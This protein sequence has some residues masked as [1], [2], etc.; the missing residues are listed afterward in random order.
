MCAQCHHELHAI[1]ITFP[2]TYK[3]NNNLTRRRT[4]YDILSWY[5]S[6]WYSAEQYQYSEY[7]MTP[8]YAPPFQLAISP[9]SQANH[10]PRRGASY[11]STN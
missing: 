5:N 4:S 8:D 2:Y 1:M 6:T 11:A 10:T 3:K 9:G 7:I